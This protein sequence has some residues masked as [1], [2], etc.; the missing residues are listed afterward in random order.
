M[1]LQFYGNKHIEGKVTK[2]LFPWKNMRTVKD[3]QD[4]NKA[5]KL[6]KKVTLGVEFLW[7]VTLLETFVCGTV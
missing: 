3:T 1:Y 5:R 7:R 6:K 2:N 4:E